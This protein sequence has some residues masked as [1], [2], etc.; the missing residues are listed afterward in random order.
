MMPTRKFE[1]NLQEKIIADIFKKGTNQDHSFNL[2]VVN[3]I[4]ELHFFVVILPFNKIF[5]KS[6]FYL[7]LHHLCNIFLG[8]LRMFEVSSLTSLLVL[9]SSKTDFLFIFVL[10]FH[11]W[12]IVLVVL[13]IP[14]KLP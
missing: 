14:K 8:T 1:Q 6:L 10:L 5:N 9:A 7:S 11:C 2:L 4:L 3:R 13:Y 12:T